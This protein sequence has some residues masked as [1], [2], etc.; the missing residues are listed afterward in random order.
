MQIALPRT[1]GTADTLIQVYEVLKSPLGQ[2][3]LHEWREKNTRQAL[4][5]AA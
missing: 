3:K 4:Q 1:D 5:P 2:Q